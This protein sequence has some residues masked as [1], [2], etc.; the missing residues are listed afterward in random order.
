MKRFKIRTPENLE[1]CFEYYLEDAPVTCGAFEKILPFRLTLYHAM[2]SGQEIWAKDAPVPDIIQENASVFAL[3]GE[4]VIGPLKPKRNKT[5]NCLGIYYGE[6][7]GLDCA[8]IFGRVSEEDLPKLKQLG[9]QIWKNGMKEIVFENV[10][11]P[12]I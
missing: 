5:A 1:I 6:G 12:N 11:A 2:V 3:P 7:K 4:I 8:N 9:E 10:I